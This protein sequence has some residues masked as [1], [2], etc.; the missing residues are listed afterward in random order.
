MLVVV[1][2]RGRPRNIAALADAWTATQA[3]ADV[4]VA[5]DDDD[6]TRGEYYDVIA[7]HPR[8]DLV[9]GPR[10]GLVGST[11]QLALANT[12]R[13]DFLGS[14]GD[15]HRPS[16]LNWDRYITEALTR[17]GTGIVYP[18]DLL[19]GERLP[20]ACFMTADIVT[21]LGWMALPACRHLFID[22]AWK[23]LG[24]RLDA[25]TYLPDVIIEHCH[26]AGGKA[27]Y[28]ETYAD[29]NSTWAQDE[30]AYRW[31][32]ANDIDRDVE[33]I[34]QHVAAVTP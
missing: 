21:A 12:D 30:A 33:K 16:S 22:D 26:P 32:L 24:E 20:T 3:H 1:P 6:P 15:D 13:Y 4:I 27:E 14:I 5:V 25:L 17:L 11:N 29:G 23:A 7:S 18:N 34:R 28:D 2:S 31:W 9:V 10:L 8:F 19:Q